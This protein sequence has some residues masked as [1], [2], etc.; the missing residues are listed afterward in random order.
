MHTTLEPNPPQSAPNPILKP[1]IP[2]PKNAGARKHL[3][4][5]YRPKPETPKTLN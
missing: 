3:L 4:T 1:Q 5:L 2:T